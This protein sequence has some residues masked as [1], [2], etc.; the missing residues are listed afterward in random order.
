MRGYEVE[1]RVVDGK[2][3]L[4]ILRRFVERLWLQYGSETDIP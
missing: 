4:R 1:I 2:S 3:G